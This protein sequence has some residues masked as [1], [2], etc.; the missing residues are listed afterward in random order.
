MAQGFVRIL[1]TEYD[2]SNE[3]QLQFGHSFL[4]AHGD[5]ICTLAVDVADAAAT[6]KEVVGRGARVALEPYT[7]ENADGAVVIAEVYTPADFRYR[8]VQRKQK[9]GAW[10]EI[11]NDSTPALFVDHL[12]VARFKEP[13]SNRTSPH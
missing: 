11:K 7:F 6:F 2:Q 13:K 8:F 12:T 9:D 1:L 4:K 10:G 3:A 5:G